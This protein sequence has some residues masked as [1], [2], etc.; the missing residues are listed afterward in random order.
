MPTDSHSLLRDVR[1]GTGAANAIMPQAHNL[2]CILTET[3]SKP[4]MA[5]QRCR[6]GAS[7]ANL[8]QVASSDQNPI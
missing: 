6:E 4:D 3:H 1:L 8:V 2:L 5:K 7:S